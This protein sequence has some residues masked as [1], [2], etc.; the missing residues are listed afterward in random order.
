MYG[1]HLA[2]M[3]WHQGTSLVWNPC[4]A[5]YGICAMRSMESAHRAV[6][7]P[8]I[9]SLSKFCE[10]GASKTEEQSDEGIS[11]VHPLG[12]MK[13]NVKSARRAASLRPRSDRKRS[14]F[15]FRLRA[16]PSA[17]DDS[18]RNVPC[19]INQ[20]NVKSAAGCMESVLCTV[21][22]LRFAQYGI[23]E[24]VWNPPSA[25]WNQLTELHPSLS[26]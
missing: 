6:F 15:G 10:R 5:R 9:L 23:R 3:V 22:N 20:T 14:P 13:T 18:G 2:E 16:P 7:F 26:S 4:S 24:A 17:Q 8:V 19:R 21:W 1:I 12:I 25:V 11:P